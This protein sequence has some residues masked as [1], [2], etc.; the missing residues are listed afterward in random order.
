MLTNAT[1]T[2]WRLTWLVSL[3]IVFSLVLVVSVASAQEPPERAASEAKM[4]ELEGEAIAGS[5]N[6]PEESGNSQQADTWICL[7]AFDAWPNYWSDQVYYYGNSTCTETMEYQRHTFFIEEYDPVEG[8]LE[9]HSTSNDCYNCR[10]LRS[11]ETAFYVFEAAAGT[12]VRVQAY[13][14]A[15]GYT[16]GCDGEWEFFGPW[17]F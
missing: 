13:Y 12:Q 7:G 8:W 14:Y 5:E 3:V 6:S 2:K 9:V 10:T 1:V 4:I 17:T 11:P 15:C 16:G